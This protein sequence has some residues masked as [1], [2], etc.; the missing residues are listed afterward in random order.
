MAGDKEI[1]KLATGFSENVFAAKAGMPA[2]HTN[3]EPNSVVWIF[4]WTHEFTPSRSVV[5]VSDVV[6]V[7]W[8]LVLMLNQF[9]VFLCS[10]QRSQL[11]ANGEVKNSLCW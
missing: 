3:L 10:Q 8:P 5:N 7:A 4:W 9:K 6:R 11:G 2:I 1:F